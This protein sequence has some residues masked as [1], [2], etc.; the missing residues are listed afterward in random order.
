MKDEK[1]ETKLEIRSE[2]LIP[3]F[4]NGYHSVDG[5]KLIVLYCTPHIPAN[6]PYLPT[7]KAHNFHM[8]KAMTPSEILH[9]P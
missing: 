4:D 5:L 6:S 9:I 3:L 2:G 8:F 7:Q 1:E